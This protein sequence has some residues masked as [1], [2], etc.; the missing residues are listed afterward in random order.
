MWP[1]VDLLRIQPM[2]QQ[3]NALFPLSLPPLFSYRIYTAANSV[4]TSSS[5]QG[6]ANNTYTKHRSAVPN[7][8]V[9]SLPLAPF[10]Q[11]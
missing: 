7:A 4:C 8:S 11:H 10:C 2:S 1:L 6:Q 9:F 3:M 5:R